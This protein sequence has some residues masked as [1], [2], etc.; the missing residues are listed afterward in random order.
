MPCGQWLHAETN[1]LSRQ[2]SGVWAARGYSISVVCTHQ[3]KVGSVIKISE[4][5]DS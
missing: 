5:K 1:G 3:G 4:D 2:T